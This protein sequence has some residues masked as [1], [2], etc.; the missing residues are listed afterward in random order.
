MRGER[1]RQYKRDAAP[2]YC[3]CARRAASGIIFI[4]PRRRGADEERERDTSFSHTPRKEMQRTGKQIE[5]RSVIALSTD[6]FSE[7]DH[8]S[9]GLKL[10]SFAEAAWKS[11]YKERGGEKERGLH[12][13]ARA[14]RCGCRKVI[15]S[16]TINEL[17]ILCDVNQN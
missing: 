15:M 10:L 12:Y 3:H 14:F 5:L 8:L 17:Y 13:L 16:K 9:F 6:C 1:Q 2:N 4:Q 11:C 7:N